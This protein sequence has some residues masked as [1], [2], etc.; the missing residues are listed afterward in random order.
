MKWL[1]WLQATAHQVDG[2]NNLGSSCAVLELA[3]EHFKSNQGAGP[4]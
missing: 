3:I 1:Y 2:H 4:K